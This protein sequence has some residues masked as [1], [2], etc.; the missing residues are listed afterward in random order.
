[1]YMCI[2]VYTKT[3]ITHPTKQ[4][5]KKQDIKIMVSDYGGYWSVVYTISDTPL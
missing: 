5:T 1:M 4:R 3:K 2:Y